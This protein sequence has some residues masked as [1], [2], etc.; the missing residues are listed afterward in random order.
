MPGN[1]PGSQV[2]GKGKDLNVSL[3][4]SAKAQGD[5]QDFARKRSCSEKGLEYFLDASKKNCDKSHRKITKQA[6]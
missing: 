6:Q 2:S 5:Q 4:V 1:S 3:A